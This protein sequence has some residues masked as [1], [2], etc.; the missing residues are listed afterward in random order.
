MIKTKKV[1]KERPLNWA[2]RLNPNSS[3]GY[4]EI[5]SLKCEL[6][7]DYDEHPTEFFLFKA[8]ES[9]VICNY[10]VFCGICLTG[11]Q[12]LN[13]LENNDDL[14]GL[15]FKHGNKEYLGI[16]VYFNAPS[17]SNIAGK[18][19]EEKMNGLEGMDNDR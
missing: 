18:F 6:S 16:L 4:S 17:F 3:R 12:K 1:E 19:F 2:S 13:V 10:F 5:F 8:N 7:K 14:P 11:S 9:S 15:I